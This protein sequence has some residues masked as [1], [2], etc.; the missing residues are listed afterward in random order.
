MSNQPTDAGSGWTPKMKLLATATDEQ[1]NDRWR[2]LEQYDDVNTP[3]PEVILAREFAAACVAAS[4][5]CACG[6]TLSPG[7]CRVCDNDE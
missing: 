5:I 2:L 4:R 1:I 3:R 7:L 6:E